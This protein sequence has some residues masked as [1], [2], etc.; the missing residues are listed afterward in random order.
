MSMEGK[1]LSIT[2]KQLYDELE[3]V[4]RSRKKK[5]EIHQQ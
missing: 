1:F 5:M 4:Q 3:N 2:N